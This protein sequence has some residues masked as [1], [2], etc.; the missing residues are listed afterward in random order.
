[1]NKILCTG[2]LLAPLFI[3]TIFSKIG[4]ADESAQLQKSG[5]IYVPAYSHIYSGD[6]E[7]P[8]LLT[9]TLSIRNMAL[10]TPVT[11]KGVDYYDSDGG[12][13]KKYVEKGDIRLKGLGA[14]RYVVAQKDK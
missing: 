1:M 4:F 7:Q 10:D 13:I 3:L 9:I 5:K 2:F 8:F 14:T 6:R 11:I 12:L